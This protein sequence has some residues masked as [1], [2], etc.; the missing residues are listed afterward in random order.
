MNFVR[1]L[2][3]FDCS[4]TGQIRTHALTINLLDKLIYGLVHSMRIIDRILYP[5]SAK[6]R[7]SSAFVGEEKFVKKCNIVPDRVDF[8]LKL[9]VYAGKT[10]NY[11]G[12]TRFYT[13]TFLRLAEKITRKQRDHSKLFEV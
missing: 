6:N 9:G 4:N 8:F 1:K 13:S 12:T 7:I 3:P 11:R 5:I 10:E 2:R